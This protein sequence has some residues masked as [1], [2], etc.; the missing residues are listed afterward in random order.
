MYTTSGVATRKLAIIRLVSYNWQLFKKLAWYDIL[1]TVYRTFICIKDYLSAYPYQRTPLS[2]SMNK[3]HNIMCLLL[4]CKAP[5]S[6][7]HR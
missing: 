1:E 6:V 2:L 4:V 3:V 5:G 7:V